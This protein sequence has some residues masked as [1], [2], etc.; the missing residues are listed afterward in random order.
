MK[1]LIATIALIGLS[2]PA[3]AADCG[4]ADIDW[5]GTT[6]HLT[7]TANGDGIR[8]DIV[9]DFVNYQIDGGD[10]ASTHVPDEATAVTVCRDGVTFELAAEPT[11]REPTES[12]QIMDVDADVYR[13][14]VAEHG[15]VAGVYPI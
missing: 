3:S 14:H 9:G 10:L 8:Y 5:V 2:I 4:T 7:K 12:Q 6:P 11:E 1:R 15:P 13:E